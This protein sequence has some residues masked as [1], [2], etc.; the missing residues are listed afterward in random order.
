MGR[1]TGGETA[2]NSNRKTDMKL[3]KLAKKTDRK[4]DIK[5]AKIQSVTDLFKLED[6]KSYLM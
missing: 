1:K 4:T 6:I 5:L 3:V 2:R